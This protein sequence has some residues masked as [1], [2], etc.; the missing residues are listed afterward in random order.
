FPPG[1]RGR[2][3]S[4]YNL[5]P[6]IGAALGIAF[7]A[8]IA[9]AFNWRDAFLAIGAIGIVAAVAIWF[10]VREPPRGAFEGGAQKDGGPSFWETVKMFFSSPTL[11][12][13]SFGS[14]ATQF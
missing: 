3:F 8:S 10:T 6:P 14:G 13:I 12:L 11:L 4:I 2:A 5:G 7:G 9:A 1:H